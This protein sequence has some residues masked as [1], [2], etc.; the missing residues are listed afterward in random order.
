MKVLFVGDVVGKPGRR[1]L[2]LFLEGKH[3]DLCVVNGENSAG[4]FGITEK[5]AKKLISYGADVITGGNHIFD[6]KEIFDFIEK[7]PILRPANYPD[8]VP[9]RGF[10]T[11]EVKGK[12]VLV[13]NLMGRV[14]MDC[15]DSPFERFD[16]I[17]EK[18]EADVVI[19]DFHAEATSEKQ[20][21]AFYVDGRASAVF[22]THTHVQTADERILEKGT[23]YITDVGM[24]GAVNSVIGMEAEQSLN[25]IRLGIPQRFKVP[26]K[27]PLIQFCGVEV[28]I[29][30]SGKVESFKRIFEV[31]E[32]L[33]DGSYIRRKKTRAR[34]QI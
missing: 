3:Y 4:G 16:A 28:E 30:E 24:C 33:E 6:R 5:V 29:G 11:V 23:F 18:E 19:V 34:S 1:A 17:V 7:Y 20:A 14:F 12:K 22:G 10:L 8:S 27:P 13:I 32:R 25:R 15:L 26:E 9:G 31:Y 21:F 2:N